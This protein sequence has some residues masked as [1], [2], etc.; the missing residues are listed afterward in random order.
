[1]IDYYDLL[2]IDRKLSE[3]ELIKTIKNDLKLFEKN[4]SKVTGQD[5]VLTLSYIYLGKRFLRTIEHYGSKENYDRALKKYNVKIKKFKKDGFKKVV[6]AGCIA[7]TLMGGIAA[8]STNYDLVNVPMYNNDTL[9]VV[10][11]DLGMSPNNL[12]YI[13]GLKAIVKESDRKRFDAKLEERKQEDIEKNKVYNFKYIVCAGDTLSGIYEKFKAV[14]VIREDGSKRS[15]HSI[16]AYEEVTIYT[17]DKEMAKAGQM[18]YDKYMMEKEEQAKFN[19]PVSFEY[20]T[21]KVGDTLPEIAQSYGVDCADIIKYNQGKVPDIY[22]IYEG[23]TLKIPQYEIN[24]SAKS[25]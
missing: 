11:S 7:G 13:R 6:L 24:I 5:K 25:K 14:D 23:D 21:V 8:F 10:A 4:K 19:N 16:D 2:G 9:E 20:Y 22:T 12:L 1:M 17:H 18:A 3:E 15:E